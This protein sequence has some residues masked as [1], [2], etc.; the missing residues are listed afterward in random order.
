MNLGPLDALKPAVRHL[1][2]MLA[3]TLLAWGGTELVPALQ[4]Q[5]GIVATVG[6]PLLTLLIAYL[7]PL[8]KQYGTASDEE[9]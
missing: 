4:G 8:T 9:V 5:G 2:L 3:A 1:V 6:A 7:T